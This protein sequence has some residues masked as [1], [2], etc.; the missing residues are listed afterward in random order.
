MKPKDKQTGNKPTTQTTTQ[1]TT[2]NTGSL[3]DDDITVTAIPAMP[4]LHASALQASLMSSALNQ[5]RS[6]HWWRRLTMHCVVQTD[7]TSLAQYTH[8]SL[9]RFRI[10]SE[11]LASCLM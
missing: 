1:P 8:D 5:L 4:H 10:G 9:V 2:N 11:R 6:A 3:F 7:T